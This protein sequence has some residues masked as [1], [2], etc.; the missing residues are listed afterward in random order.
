[1][2]D[3]SS[4]TL[5]CGGKTRGERT[6]LKK[7]EFE[8]LVQARSV[9]STRIIDMHSKHVWDIP[10]STFTFKSQVLSLL[11]MSICQTISRHYTGVLS[12]SVIESDIADVAKA[13]VG[14]LRWPIASMP[15]LHSFL[16]MQRSTSTIINR[17][18]TLTKHLPRAYLKDSPESYLRI[19]GR[20]QSAT[21]TWRKR[22]RCRL[23]KTVGDR[24]LLLS[25][26]SDLTTLTLP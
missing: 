12:F 26:S 21:M 25:S 3:R 2:R 8:K 10:F 9:T 6:C 19:P 7:K 16:R 17:Q 1:M 14:T 4:Y 20:R 23:T 5:F 24:L 11:Y 13:I 18:L 15:F 22:S